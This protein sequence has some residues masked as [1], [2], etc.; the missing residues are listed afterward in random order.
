MAIEIAIDLYTHV[1]GV[2]VYSKHVVDIQVE[3]RAL[4]AG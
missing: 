3:W 2:E 4:V 1:L